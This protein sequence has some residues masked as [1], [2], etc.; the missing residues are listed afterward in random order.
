METNRTPL[1]IGGAN[2]EYLFFW[3]LGFPGERLRF[4]WG[5]N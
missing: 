3:M 4:A 1:P 2:A 5:G